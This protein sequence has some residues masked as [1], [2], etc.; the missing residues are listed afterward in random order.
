MV[1]GCASDTSCL[2]FTA[3]LNLLPFT[4]TFAVDHSPTASNLCHLFSPSTHTPRFASN[5]RIGVECRLS[6]SRPSARQSNAM[7]KSVSS[8]CI[9][10]KPRFSMRV[11]SVCERF[12][13]P[14]AR[15]LSIAASAWSI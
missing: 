8:S 5:F 12:N 7:S 2:P 3:T 9:T 15:Q 4:L 13:A 10:Q 11:C 1:S 14:S 6:V